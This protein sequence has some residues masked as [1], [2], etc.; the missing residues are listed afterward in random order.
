[1]ASTLTKAN[2]QKEIMV[3]VALPGCLMWWIKELVNN[4]NRDPGQKAR[5]KEINFNLG[6]GKVQKRYIVMRT[7]PDDYDAANDKVVW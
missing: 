4:I 1:M 5:I 2:R 7:I 6:H 3:T